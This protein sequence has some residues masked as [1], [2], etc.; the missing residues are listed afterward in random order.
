MVSSAQRFTRD[1]PCPICGGYHKQQRHQGQRCYGFLSDEGKWAHCT[2]EELAGGIA[3]KDGSQTYAH[4]L[5]G[6]CRCGQRHDNRP[7][8]PKRGSKRPSRRIVATYDYTDEDGTL[9]FQ[10]VRYDPKDFAQRQPD[11]KGGW[12]WNLE[13]VRR[14]LYRLPELLAADP[15]K[16]V[17]IVEGEKDADNLIKLGLVATTNPMG[18]GKWLPEYSVW[19]EGRQVVKVPDNDRTGREDAVKVAYSVQ[20]VAKSVR[21]LELAGL[22]DQGD[23]SDWLGQGH[24]IDELVDLA[25]KAPEWEPSPPG[26]NRQGGATLEG[27]YGMADGGIVWNKPLKDGDV[28]VYLT[29][30]TAEITAQLIEDDGVETRRSLEIEARFQNRTSRFSVGAA[31]FGGMG[32]TMEHLGARAVV[33]PGSTL[34]DHARTAIQLLSKDA[35]ERHV[36]THTGWRK[37]GKHWAFLHAGGAI[38]AN[39]SLPDAEVHLPGDLRNYMLP[40][41]PEGAELVQ[42][43]R[44]SLRVLELADDAITVPINAGTYR[45]PLGGIDAAIHLSGA[46]G[47]GKTALAALAQQHFGPGMDARHLPGSWSSTGNALEGLAFHAKDAILSVDD[48]APAGSATDVQRM[49]RE[50]DR[51]IRAQGNSSGRMRMRADATLK[52]AKPP[53][54]L[55]L[56]TGEDVPKGQSLRARMLVIETGKDALDWDKLTACQEDAA[57]GLYAQAMAAYVRWLAPRYQGISDSLK[58]QVDALRAEAHLSGRHRR[59]AD[60]VANLGVGF[61]HFLAFAQESGAVTQ[62]EADGLWQRCWRALG[63]AAE[64]QGAHQLAAEPATRFLELL[65]AAIAS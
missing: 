42:A 10:T 4:R 32:W 62:G 18:A 61:R 63:E 28:P 38:G 59:T 19:L 21:V 64:A 15:A 13:G 3:M 33:Y 53:R 34:K 24:T 57:N 5:T 23:V 37:L 56:S 8:S 41:P 52:P 51:L 22:P 58:T 44:A 65:S 45:A 39:G 14:V 1:Q 49:H 29:N 12:K 35:H 47:E 27:R 11:G 26:E 40:E 31:Q 60:L 55:I 50:A 36:Y 17:F 54:G 30:F 46:T 16:P 6:D 7:P 2:R 20:G 9:L 43:I 25:R 48:F